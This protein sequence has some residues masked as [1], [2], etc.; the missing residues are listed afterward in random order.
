MGRFRWRGRERGTT[1]SAVVRNTR[2]SAKVAF[3]S[4]FTLILLEIYSNRKRKGSRQVLFLNSITSCYDLLRFHAKLWFRKRYKV[5]KRGII[6][7]KRA[8]IGMQGNKGWRDCWYERLCCLCNVKLSV[9]QPI[10]CQGCFN[11]LFIYFYLSIVE[12]F[13]SK[14]RVSSRED[15]GRERIPHTWASSD[16]NYLK[17]I[18]VS[19]SY[20]VVILRTAPHWSVRMLS[21]NF[22]LLTYEQL[23]KNNLRIL[24]AN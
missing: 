17:S 3:T 22:R 16:E 11:K 2:K 12:W 13:S 24:G 4:K 18:F 7:Y 6:C 1:V 8:L 15:E 21:C 19:V 20:C 9:I 10:G 14:Y 23:I 5:L